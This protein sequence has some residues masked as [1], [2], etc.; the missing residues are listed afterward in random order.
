MAHSPNECFSHFFLVGISTAYHAETEPSV[1]RV[2]PASICHSSFYVRGSTSHS[3]CMHL[4]SLPSP[5]PHSIMRDNPA[6]N[7]YAPITTLFQP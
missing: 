6:R 4:T 3:L 7:S 1:F 2:H 5:A